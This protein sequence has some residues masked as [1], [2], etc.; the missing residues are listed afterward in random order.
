MLDA[1]V[2]GPCAIVEVIDACGVILVGRTRVLGKNLADVVPRAI[3]LP[4]GGEQGVGQRDIKM[5]VSCGLGKAIARVRP[6]I[7]ETEIG[8]DVVDGGTIEEV[9]SAD[10]EHG[11][12]VG[13]VL[14][15]QQ[16]DAGEPDRVGSERRAC[17]EDAHAA[18]ASEPWW[19]D[20]GTPCVGIIGGGDAVEAP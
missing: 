5:V 4:N 3:V 15:A 19:S 6:G 12:A 7:G 1:K 9:R 10:D 8:F 18:V 17:G 2:N 11:P 14:D 16:F 13:C 20:S